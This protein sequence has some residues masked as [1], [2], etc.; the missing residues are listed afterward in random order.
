MFFKVPVIRAILYIISQSAGAIAGSAV[1]R[2]LSDEK[3]FSENKLGAV[4]ITN[5]TAVQGFGIEFFLCLILVMVVC[6]ACDSGKPESKGI[7]PLIIG[8]TVAA[9]H[10]I[11]VRYLFL[12]GKFPNFK[13]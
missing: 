8:L 9:C 13:N 12:I 10:L 6:G 5:I 1:L 4:G 2:A 3:N 11:A 7:A